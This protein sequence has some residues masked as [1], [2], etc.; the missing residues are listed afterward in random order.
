MAKE[1]ILAMMKANQPTISNIPRNRIGGALADVLSTIKSKTGVVGDFLL[2]QAPEVVDQMSYGFNPT[3]GKNMTFGLKPEAADLANIIPFGT[4][5][6]LAGKGYAKLAGKELARQLQTG[7]GLVGKA[8]MNP[9]MGITEFEKNHIE[10]QADA[11]KNHG[12]LE[13]NTAMDRAKAMGFDTPA[14]H[15]T[16]YGD[17]HEFLPKG[18]GEDSANTLEWYRN[19]VSNNER[20]GG[21]SF[22]NGSFFSPKAEYANHYTNENKG[23]MYPVQLKMDNPMYHDQN[24]NWSGS[25]INK[26][27]DAMIIK[28]ADG[29]NEIS[30]IEPNNIRSKFAAFNMSNAN[31]NDLLGSATPALMSVLAGGSGAGMAYARQLNKDRK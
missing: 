10:A 27:Q 24:G 22:R 11:F 8:A 2:G 13:N 25:N 5:G 18:G 17:I 26:S 12:L 7:T 21:M 16:T 23:V 15:G 19:R 28:D 14:Y 31:S 20:I 4:L 29:V 3:R 6:G 9:R 1:D 30:I